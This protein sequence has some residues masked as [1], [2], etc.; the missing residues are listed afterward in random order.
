M[1]KIVGLYAVVD[2]ADLA[3]ECLTGGCSLI[4]LRQKGQN[5]KNEAQ[6][7][8]ALKARHDFIFILNDDPQLA[9]EIGADGVHLG[10][11]DMPVV[12]ARKLLG[13]KVIIGKST[14][15]VEE[16][17]IAEEEPTTYVA[18][19]AIFPTA[20]KGPDHPIIGLEGLKAIRKAVSKPLVAIG[21]INRSNAASVISAGADAIAM[22]SALRKNIE[23]EVQY[24][25][26]LFNAGTYSEGYFDLFG[27]LQGSGLKR[28]PQPKFKD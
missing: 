17:M 27:S 24:Y 16:A 10:Q 26:A 14:H 11:G 15:S 13:P 1:K 28:P 4:Q 5:Q 18:A 8:K 21:G 20:A 19:G 22:I 2:S 9:L 25:R 3:Q 7:I 12:E 6:K 23:H